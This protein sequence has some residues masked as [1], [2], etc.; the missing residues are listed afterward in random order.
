LLVQRPARWL[1][2]I[3]QDGYR[4]ASRRQGGLARDYTRT[5]LDWSH[6]YPRPGSATPSCT[7]APPSSTAKWPFKMI[8]APRLRCAQICP[9]DGSLI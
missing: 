2:E 5:G 7:A 4:H 1:H 3:K 6:R 8:R 9:L